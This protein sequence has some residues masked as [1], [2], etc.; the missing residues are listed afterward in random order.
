M[1]TKDTLS[2]QLEKA[3]KSEKPYLCTMKIVTNSYNHVSKA[4]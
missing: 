3:F 4:E 2:V 1:R